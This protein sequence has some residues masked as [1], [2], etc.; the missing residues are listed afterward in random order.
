[1]QFNILGSSKFLVVLDDEGALFTWYWDHNE[2]RWVF[3][4]TIKYTDSTNTH[5]VVYAAV[6]PDRLRPKSSSCNAFIIWAESKLNSEADNTNAAQMSILRRDF[7]ITLQSSSAQDGSSAETSNLKKSSSSI[8]LTS[9]SK[10]TLHLQITT[11]T[12]YV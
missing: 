12:C 9:S 11:S 10:C 1:M 5:R 8:Q 4:S 7:S 2:I 6:R 3:I